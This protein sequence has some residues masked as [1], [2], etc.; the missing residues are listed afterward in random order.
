LLDEISE[1]AQELVDAL[2][3][4]CDREV[5][6]GQWCAWGDGDKLRRLI[7]ARSIQVKGLH[8][9]A[10]RL[11]RFLALVGRHSYIDTLHRDLPSLRARH[12]QALAEQAAVGLRLVE[13]VR[14][15]DNYVIFLER[16][17]DSKAVHFNLK[18][19]QMPL[20]AAFLDFVH[21][22]IGFNAAEEIL[23]PVIGQVPGEPAETVASRLERAL[24]GWLE[25]RL[26]SEHH[27]RQA[28]AMRDFLRHYVQPKR[29]IDADSVDDEAV[30]A[31]WL[32]Q[33]ANAD[34]L[35]FRLFRSAARAMISFHF[36]MQ[37]AAYEEIVTKTLDPESVSQHTEN[38]NAF[39]GGLEIYEWSSPLQRMFTPPADK[40]KWLTDTDRDLLGVLIEDIESEASLFSD[41][42]PNERFFLTL[43]RYAVFGQWQNVFVQRVKARKLL[44]EVLSDG[45]YIEFVNRFDKLAKKLKLLIEA[46]AWTLTRRREPSSLVLLQAINPDWVRHSVGVARAREDT[47]EDDTDDGVTA[48]RID[49]QAIVR[50]VLARFDAPGDPLAQ[51]LRAS[52]H[53]VNRVGFRPA[54]EGDATIGEALADGSGPVLEVSRE[55]CRFRDWA[56][57]GQLAT[58]Y[59][60]DLAVF[61]HAF[62]AFYA[63]SSESVEARAD[64]V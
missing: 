38:E 49:I 32:S 61:K 39:S 23:R 18:F 22:A 27:I 31:F 26:A 24:N 25:G 58:R 9:Q 46:T 51:Q 11:A 14:I 8:R 50:L 52:Y 29:R 62:S 15:A 10:V 19:G 6:S 30:L 5:L 1:G 40:I 56:N 37:L 43:V 21:N 36:A 59:A 2:S 28:R 4:T 42:R 57:S 20:V 16:E 48:M 7:A 64:V 60:E 54:D 41:N 35:G 44:P 3:A 34:A 63:P 45:G 47:D 33:K 12:F 17:M 53:V 13:R 55:V